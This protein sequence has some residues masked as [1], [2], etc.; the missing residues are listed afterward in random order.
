MAVT[1]D[2]Q[3]TAVLNETECQRFIFFIKKF[4]ELQRLPLRAKIIRA[5][6]VFI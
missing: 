1:S 5:S 3:I 4:D 6:C 2:M